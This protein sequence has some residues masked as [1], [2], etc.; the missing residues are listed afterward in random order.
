MKAIILNGTD[1]DDPLSV[2]TCSILNEELT[3]RDYTVN[4]LIL[5]DIDIADCMGCFG[6]WVKSPG[7]CVIDD[8]GRDVAMR[9]MRNDLVIYMTP[10]TF[11]GYSYELK[12]AVDRI[13]PNIL[14][15]FMKIKG[16]IHHKKR[17]EHC[18]NLMGL[19]LLPHSDEESERIFKT[20]IYRNAIN[21]HS[22]KH[23]GVI[24]YGDQ[25]HDSI[26]QK[27]SECLSRY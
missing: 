17:Y 15:F 12:K 9:I 13:I 26:R 2:N 14:P 5:Q 19:G 10:V 16:E 24:V 6:C 25:A 27:I 7:V 20:L 23:E 1:K 11:G 8:A 21:M 3:K 22:P 4:M 18:Y